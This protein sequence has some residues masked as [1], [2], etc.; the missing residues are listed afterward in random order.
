MIKKRYN[1]AVCVAGAIVFSALMSVRGVTGVDAISTM[2]RL[3]GVSTQADANLAEVAVSGSADEITVAKACAAVVQYQV[4]QGSV[5]KDKLMAALQAGDA[6]KAEAAFGELN[7][8]LQV[9]LDALNGVW[10]EE[11]VQI[12]EVEMPGSSAEIQAVVE[13]VVDVEQGEETSEP[14]NT[15]DVP[16]ES[17]S[18]RSHQEETYEDY[19]DTGTFGSTDTVDEDPATGE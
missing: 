6:D 5:A 13:V 19:F 7:A 16:W 8:A 17:D 1:K 4:K 2:V 14:P 3:N 10:P 18:V 12:L 15:N 9:A 11:L